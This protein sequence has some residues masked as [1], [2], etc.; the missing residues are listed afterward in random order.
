MNVNKFK[1]L[2]EEIDRYVNIPVEMQWDFTGR[3]EAIDEYEKTML[4]EVLGNAKDFE[5]IRF[6]HNPNTNSFTDINYEFYFYDN[7]L[8]ITSPLV[9]A[10]NWASSYLTT[11]FNVEQIYYYTNPFTKSFFKLDFYDTP[12]ETTQKNYFTV[13]I[14][15][16][17]G[18]SQTA[19]LSTFVPPVDIRIPTFKL[20]FVGDK[21]GFFLYWL[22][23]RDY[24]DINTFY[25]SAKFFDARIGVFVRMTN[26]VQ[27]ILLPTKFTFNNSDFFYYK[28]TL[29]YSNFTYKVND[30]LTLLQVGD[31]GQPIKWYEYVNP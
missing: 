14:P 11:G 30:V 21:E 8:P 18:L 3:D 26:R 10:A 24:I 5:V 17:Q 28:V 13:I 7:L 2:Q 6:S 20:D 4:E 1:I 16:Q 15:V 27:P 31:A 23:N 29:D 12:N 22:R 19:L 9:T 25:M